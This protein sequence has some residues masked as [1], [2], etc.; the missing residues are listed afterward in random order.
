MLAIL[1]AGL[2]A[3]AAPSMA[4]DGVSAQAGLRLVA[5][6]PLQVVGQ[7]FQPLE[8]VTLVATVRDD[9]VTRRFVAT[10]AGRFRVAFRTLYV[11]RCTS[12]GVRARGS[13]GTRATLAQRP[14]TECPEPAGP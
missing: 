3:A 2:I 14:L 4:L 1:V 8:H 5:M 7:G 12:F 9:R 13:A 10:R 11:D 6:R